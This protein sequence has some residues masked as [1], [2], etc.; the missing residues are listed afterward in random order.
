MHALI[1]FRTLFALVALCLLMGGTM[2]Q[3]AAQDAATTA[4]SPLVG[5][6]LVPPTAE[7]TGSIIALSS[8]GIVVDHETDDTLGTGVWNATGPTSGVMTFVFFMASE[9]FTGN[10]IIRANLDYDEATDTLTAS[11]NV[12]GT[13]PDGTVVWA[14]EELSSNTLT[15]MPA[16]GPDAGTLPLDGISA[17]ATAATPT[18]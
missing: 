2:T 14:Q 16:Q 8:D 10:I 18:A 6:W 9:E 3:V 1:R 5:V 17:P 11:Y 13:T 4:G 7:D 15:R 12:T